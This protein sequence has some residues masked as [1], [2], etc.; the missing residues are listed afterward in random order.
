MVFRR[1]RVR[2]NSH[3]TSKTILWPAV[4][5]L[6]ASVAPAAAQY[7]VGT[8]FIEGTPIPGSKDLWSINAGAIPTKPLSIEGDYVA[9][10]QCGQRCGPI[11]WTYSIWALN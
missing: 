10:V 1:S 6:L 9:F 8:L 3:L 11:Y 4:A 2:R 5:A 7:D